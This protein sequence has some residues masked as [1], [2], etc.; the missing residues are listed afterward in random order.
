M[1]MRFEIPNRICLVRGIVRFNNQ[2]YSNSQLIKRSNQVELLDKVVVVLEEGVAVSLSLKCCHPV[3]VV[4]V[5]VYK[6][7][8][9]SSQNLLTSSLEVLFF[10]RQSNQLTSQ[11]SLGDS[12]VGIVVIRE[13]NVWEID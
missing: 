7:P 10:E 2:C 8:K 3:K 5:H 4:D 12:I 9:H 1:M 13:I 11:L 6:D